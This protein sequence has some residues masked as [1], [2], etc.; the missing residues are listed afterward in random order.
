MKTVS[1]SSFGARLRRAQDLLTYISG[2]QVYKPPRPDESIE[3][4][5]ILIDSIIAANATESVQREN[6]RAAVAVRQSAFTRKDG[7]VQKLLSPIKGAVDAQYGKNSSE[8]TNLNSLIKKMRATKIIKAPADP[9]KPE[10]EKTVS[11]SERSYGSV[12]QHFND[13]VNTISQFS[14]YDSSNESLTLTALQAFAAK[15][16]DYN[17]DV[18]QK[19][20]QLKA[21]KASRLDKYED[22]RDRVQ[23]VKAYIRAHYGIKSNEYKLISGLKF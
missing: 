23:R 6:Y 3:N 4:L 22:L 18:A 5:T 14:S 7:S 21:T 16:T 2:Y 8:A 20:Q 17:N 19:T 9:T 15:L 13:I 1:E 12:T 11:Q 10:N